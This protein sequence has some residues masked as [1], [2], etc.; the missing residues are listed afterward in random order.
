MRTLKCDLIA[1]LSLMLCLCSGCMPVWR[2]MP[3]LPDLSRL[4]EGDIVLTFSG[5]IESWCLALSSG[6]DRDQGQIPYTHAEAVYRDGRGRLMLG[7]VSQGRVRSRRLKQAF[8][9]FQ[10]IAVYRANQPADRR[11]QAACLLRQWIANPNIRAATFDYTLQDVPGRRDKFCCV[12]FLNELF[13]CSALEAPFRVGEWTPNEAGRHFSELLGYDLSHIILVDS[14]EGHPGYHNVF[15]WKN[16][17]V[18]MKR[19][20]LRENIAMQTLSWYDMGW[21]L[22]TSERFHIGLALAHVPEPVKRLDRTRSQLCQFACDVMKMWSRLERRG[23]IKGLDHAQ[24]M[25]L[26]QAVCE[27]YR[28]R[29]FYH[30]DHPDPNILSLRSNANTGTLGL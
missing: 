1:T 21:R 9:E 29:Y 8:P 5:A 7:G 20:Q 3:P 12:G 30:R 24:Q 14:V 23:R 15:T 4:E 10:H 17:R 6:L 26:L 28:D 19:S 2:P 13:R 16:E 11:K 27:K 22:K 25:D 18:D